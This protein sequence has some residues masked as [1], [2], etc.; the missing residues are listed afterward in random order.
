MR[1]VFI[2]ASF[3]ADTRD[4]KRLPPL[5]QRQ[6]AH[7]VGIAALVDVLAGHLPHDHLPSSVGDD[8]TVSKHTHTHTHTNRYDS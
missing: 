3:V 5:G 1:G 8:A 6:R 4:D 2:I 7:S